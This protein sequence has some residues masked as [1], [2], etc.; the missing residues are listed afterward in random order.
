MPKNTFRIV[1]RGTDGSLRIRD[2][3]KTEQL[4]RMHTQVGIEDSSTDL[5]LRGL[6]VFR[7][8]I[9]PIP[10]GK[11][12]VRYETPEVFELMTKEWGNAKPRRRRRRSSAEV[13]EEKARLAEETAAT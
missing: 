12:I 1:T 4:Q 3:D 9:G 6:P 5:S 7:G 8:L 11:N 2:Y 13:A 10:E